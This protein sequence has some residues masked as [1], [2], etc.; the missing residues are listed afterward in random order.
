MCRTNLIVRKGGGEGGREGTYAWPYLPYLTAL[1][2]TYELV[3]PP[4]NKRKEG[5]MT[6][7]WDSR[8]L[9][10]ANKCWPVLWVFC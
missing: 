1:Y 8:L 5:R 2:I 4:Y 6:R 7:H 3:G 10:G 9:A